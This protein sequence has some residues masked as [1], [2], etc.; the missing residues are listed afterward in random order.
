MRATVAERTNVCLFFSS[1]KA[2]RTEVVG[3]SAGS[4]WHPLLL[5]TSHVNSCLAVLVGA[6]QQSWVWQR[7]ADEAW[8]CQWDLPFLTPSSPS[9]PRAAPGTMA[10]MQ[11]GE[12][13]QVGGFVSSAAGQ[14]LQEKLLVPFPCLLQV[15]KVGPYPALLFLRLRE[16]GPKHT[17][18]SRSPFWTPAARIWHIIYR[19]ACKMGELLPV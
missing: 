18:F 3:Q 15:C 13:L 4:T 2:P 16:P 7:A 14:L 5:V 12:L 17:H 6:L 8:G 10:G 19:S 1:L 11:P 9:P